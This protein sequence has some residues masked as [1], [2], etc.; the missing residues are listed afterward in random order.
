MSVDWGEAAVAVVRQIPFLTPNRHDR[1]KFSVLQNA[2]PVVQK[3]W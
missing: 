2:P 3:M 1:D